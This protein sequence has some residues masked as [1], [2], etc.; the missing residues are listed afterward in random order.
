MYRQGIY[1]LQKIFQQQ[2]QNHARGAEEANHDGVEPVDPKRQAY[3]IACKVQEEQ[4]H[5]TNQSVDQ[6]FPGQFDGSGQKFENQ[7]VCQNCNEYDSYEFQVCNLPFM[8]Y[9][10]PSGIL[11]RNRTGP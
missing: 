11:R 6:Q 5:K 10:M 9:Q 7:N 4:C 2:Q 1:V 3:K 8:T